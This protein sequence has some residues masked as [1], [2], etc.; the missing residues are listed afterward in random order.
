MHAPI[1]CRIQLLGMYSYSAFRM[2]VQ[3]QII[4]HSR[5]ILSTQ[6]MHHANHSKGHFCMTSGGL[7][8]CKMAGMGGFSTARLH[9][10]TGTCSHFTPT[11]LLETFFLK[12]EERGCELQH[13]RN[14]AR[15]Y[16]LDA[17][18]S[19]NTEMVLRC[20]FT[21]TSGKMFSSIRKCSEGAQVHHSIIRKHQKGALL[22]GGN[23]GGRTL[24]GNTPC[25]YFLESLCF[26]TEPSCIDL[27][28]SLRHTYAHLFDLLLYQHA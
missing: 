4:R 21:K 15:N 6:G 3:N 22:L 19:P 12:K 26:Q 7:H 5:S 1:P 27:F 11:P 8:S 9:F 16:P 25:L 24:W 13:Q 20:T 14:G 10:C 2:N 23:C 18:F 17:R 28:G